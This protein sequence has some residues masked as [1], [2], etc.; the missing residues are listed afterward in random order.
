MSAP[1]R[2]RDPPARRGGARGRRRRRAQPATRS[3]IT[4]PGRPTADDARRRS[5]YAR[6]R[7][8]AGHRDARPRGGRRALCRARWTC[9]SAP[10]P[11]RSSAA[12]ELLLALGE[13]LVR[14][15][16]RAHGLADVPRGGRRWPS[17]WATAPRWR[18]LRSAPP[19]ATCSRP[20][21]STPELI[22]LLERALEATA[23]ERTVTRVRLL[24]RLC[25]AIYFSPDRDRMHALSER[26]DGASPPSSPTPRRAL[27]VRPPGAARCGTPRTW[28]AGSRRPP[29]C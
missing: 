4:S 5:R 12:C 21:W 9:S 20:G 29:R 22:A 18:G 26:G 28:R 14:A 17:G 23:G 7:R 25:G 10:I 11:T 13:A 27:R 3:P 1:R 24:A 6:A 2:A 19:A 8:R 16:E 15:G